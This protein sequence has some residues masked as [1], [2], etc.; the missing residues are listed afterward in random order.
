MNGE[1]NIELKENFTQVCVW[2]GTIVKEEQIPDMVE[3]FQDELGVRIQYL[4]TI[5][6]KPDV[7]DHANISGGRL[8]VF[9]AIHDEDVQKFAIPKLE[10][11]MRWIED[12]L[13][14]VNGYFENPIYPERV[15]EYKSWD[16]EE[17]PAECRYDNEREYILD[18]Y[19]CEKGEENG[20]N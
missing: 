12:V 20:K 5:K 14:E 6:T 3:W 15:E 18:N 1:K 16:E 19:C 10:L 7:G 13:S 2:P 17:K 11:G 8:D 9:I 4:E